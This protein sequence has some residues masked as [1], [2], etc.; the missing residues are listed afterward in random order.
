VAGA[1]AAD[2]VTVA[3]MF[4]SVETCRAQHSIRAGDGV[5][6]LLFAGRASW[7]LPD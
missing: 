4:S 1:A 2:S 6:R 5:Y 7:G 3:M